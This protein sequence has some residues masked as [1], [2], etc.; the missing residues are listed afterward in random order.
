[1]TSHV[2]PR[3]AA[4]PV[5]LLRAFTSLRRSLTLYPPGHRLIERNVSELLGAVRDATCDA[6]RVRIEILAGIAHLAGYP[7]RV[8]SRG[9]ADTVAEWADDGIQCLE[10]DGDVDADELV[11]AASIANQ[12]SQGGLRGERVVDAFAKA[13]VRHIHMSRLNPVETRLPAFEWPDAPES[14]AARSY[15]ETLALARETV[16]T[17]FGGADLDPARIEALLA[18][19]ADELLDDR[20]A[21]AE[22]MA[23][24]EYEN[25]TFCHSVNVAALALMLGRRVGLDRAAQGA[26][27]EAALLHDIGKRQIPVAILQKAGELSRRER[28]IIERH[29]VFGAEILACTRSLSPLAATVALEHHR[30]FDG[31]GYPDLQGQRPHE[32]SQIVAVVDIYEALTGARPYRAPMLPEEACLIL[33]RMAGRH[34]N[35]ALVRAFVSLISFFPIGSIVRTTDGALGVV[36]ETSEHDP[37]HP[38][39][40]VLDPVDLSRSGTRLDTAERGPGGDYRRHIAETLRHASAPAQFRVL[41]PNPAG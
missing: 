33:A 6:P 21:M 35:P 9:H 28:R 38:V 12:L 13:G 10:I 29:P 15:A 22:I 37:L 25:H 23:I 18:R 2:A 36:V 14:V 39:L 7:F 19:I 32:M 1:M 3:Q 17:A 24:K 20:V 41:A 40:E 16:G 26:L 34:L 31:T 27:G 30:R 8:G 11:A 4:D 5:E